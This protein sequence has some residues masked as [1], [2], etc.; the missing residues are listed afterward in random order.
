M[1]LGSF[2]QTLALDGSDASPL[3]FLLA[4]V[5]ALGVFV[6]FILL[7]GVYVYLSFT[8]SAIGRKARVK[9]PGIAWIPIFGPLIIAYKSSK[10]HWWPWL[11]VI[12]FFIPVLNVIAN[13]VFTVFTVIWHWKMFEAIKK[14][15]W[16]AILMLIPL[17]N[18]V[19]VGIAAW[20]KR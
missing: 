20:S 11:L 9:S 1:F 12:G 7:L 8:Y 4:M 2:L 13:L 3:I 17:V 15:N 5:A 16:W 6:F 10:M 14:P 19:I 18:F